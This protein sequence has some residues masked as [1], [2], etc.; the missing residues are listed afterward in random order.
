MTPMEPMPLT[1]TRHT[2]AARRV[3]QGLI[4]LATAC[5]LLVLAGCVPAC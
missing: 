3:V 2:A 5:S 4:A 1:T